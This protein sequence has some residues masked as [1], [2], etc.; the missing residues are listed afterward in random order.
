MPTPQLT[1]KLGSI[2][3][4]ATVMSFTHPPSMNSFYSFWFDDLLM[5]SSCAVYACCFWQWESKQFVNISV[6]EN[7]C[8]TIWVLER[9]CTKKKNKTTG[10][11][12]CKHGL[13]EKNR[14]SFDMTH[15]VNMPE[16]MLFAFVFFSFLSFR[17]FS[18][19]LL[20]YYNSGS[21]V[22]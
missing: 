5:F 6:V 15:F 17:F 2:H 7:Y 21:I 14:Q 3:L 13:C 9:K 16:R 4:V 19:I 11:T 10:I 22:K 8:L 18:F 20:H 12:F 1:F